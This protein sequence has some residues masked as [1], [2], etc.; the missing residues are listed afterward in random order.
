[1]IRF[2]TPPVMIQVDEADL[3]SFDEIYVT[4][5]QAGVRIDKTP[6]IDDDTLIVKLSQSESASFNKEFPCRVMVNAMKNGDRYASDEMLMNVKENL[7][8]EVLP[9]RNDDAH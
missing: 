3:S 8:P 2:T 1:M 5:S 7:L 6:T 9:L 4:F